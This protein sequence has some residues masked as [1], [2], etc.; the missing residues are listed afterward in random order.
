MQIISSPEG[1]SL[2]KPI[3]ELDVA[4]VRKCIIESGVDADEINANLEMGSTLSRPVSVIV[5]A[6]AWALNVREAV[7]TGKEIPPL[8]DQNTPPDVLAVGLQKIC[9]RIVENLIGN[10]E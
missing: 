9:D 4:A 3:N 6:G 1:L 10:P 7:N 2:L 5:L 8:L